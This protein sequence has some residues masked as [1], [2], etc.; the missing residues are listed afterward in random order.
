MRTPWYPETDLKSRDA[1][2]ETRRAQIRPLQEVK[3]AYA[4]AR[5]VNPDDSGYDGRPHRGGGAR[6]RAA[7][8]G[9]AIIG[10]I[11]LGWL[12]N[13][14]GPEPPA[15]P[16]RSRMRPPVASPTP[17]SI[18]DLELDVAVEAATVI[19]PEEPKEHDR[20]GR[21]QQRRKAPAEGGDGAGGGN[22]D[23]A[24]EVSTG[25]TEETPEGNDV[26]PSGASQESSGGDGG[27]SGGSGGSSG[28]SGSSGSG[29]GGS[30]GS[31]ASGDTGGGA[32]GDGWPGGSGGGGGA[33]G[34]GGG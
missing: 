21:K 13:S 34:G 16:T 26:A 29:G 19:N 4:P 7:Q 33:G 23:A 22:Q 32:G 30:G 17:V 20:E 31:D 12:A 14:L 27:T 2:R 11:L 24:V 25:S 3:Q 5:L 15:M 18:A 9:A 1:S 8:L 6:L 28:G 10:G